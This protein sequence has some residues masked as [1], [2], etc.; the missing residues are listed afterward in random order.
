M[1]PRSILFSLVPDKKAFTLI[2]V[3]VVLAI[4]V[5]LGAVGGAFFF[6]QR[7]A[8]KEDRARA[9]LQ[10]V[11]LGLEAY[12]SRFGD[13]PRVPDSFASFDEIGNASEYLLNALNGQIGPNHDDLSDADIPPMLNNSLLT[14]AEVELPLTHIRK[15]HIV[16][17]W[18]N[19]Y[20]YDSKPKREG[21]LKL[22]F[23]YE[24]KSLGPDGEE[25]TDDIFAK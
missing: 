6:G 13:Y 7:A 3:M 20:L 24:L 21:D 12:R 4:L 17:P 9:D 25:G 10:V 22:L 2:E 16:D 11:Q 14:F 23:G 1:M 8:A 5:V 19:A 18:G 15:N